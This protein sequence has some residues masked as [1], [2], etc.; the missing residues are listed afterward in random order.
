MILG[1]ITANKITPCYMFEPKYP[2]E[3]V[4]IPFNR[5]KFGVIENRYGLVFPNTRADFQAAEKLFSKIKF[6]VE[7]RFVEML[8]AIVAED[9]LIQISRLD[10]EKDLKD[11]YFIPMEAVFLRREKNFYLPVCCL[12]DNPNKTIPPFV[13]KNP[14]QVLESEKFLQPFLSKKL[15][16]LW[17]KKLEA[18]RRNQKH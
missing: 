13:W 1:S 6:V 3:I 8:A 9:L 2:I 10:P 16:I 12:I 5:E 11:I 18:E 14:E 15:K 7:N 4:I 17:Q